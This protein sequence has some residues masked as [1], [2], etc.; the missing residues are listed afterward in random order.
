[1]KQLQQKLRFGKYV[2]LAVGDAGILFFNG[3]RLR[4]ETC[5]VQSKAHVCMSLSMSEYIDDKMPPIRIDAKRKKVPDAE[6]TS[7][8][9]TLLRTLVARFMWVAR[10]ARP[11][12]A[13]TAALLVRQLS[14]PLVKD[15]VEAQN[16]LEHLHAIK[17]LG[18]RYFAVH[19]AT[20]SVVAITD[21]SPSTAADVHA[22]GGFLVAL[23]SPELLA[24]EMCAMN[25]VAWRLAKIERICNSSLAAE[26]YATISAFALCKL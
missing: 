13:G 19:L 26:S 1:M 10:E 18:L 4:L 21:F 2:D 12:L 25:L 17:A 14:N 23:S 15:L 9:A 7:C 6:L 22:Q 20:A 5:Q 11:D 24:H 3:R 8:E 16:A